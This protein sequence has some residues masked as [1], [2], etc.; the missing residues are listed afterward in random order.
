MTV[1]VDG[2]GITYNNATV[3]TVALVPLLDRNTSP[4]ATSYQIGTN[5][6]VAQIQSLISST[7]PPVTRY[8]SDYSGSAYIIPWP[9]MY[10]NVSYSG[11][12]TYTSVTSVTGFCTHTS[13]TRLF[14]ATGTTY[15]ALAG[16]WV[17]RGYLGDGNS[18]NTAYSLYQLFQRIS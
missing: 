2:S 6:L 16:V 9:T 14:S 8:N 7:Q 4:T 12:P 1:T 18:P 17:S 11:S 13:S 10:F 15:S 5:I 3:Q